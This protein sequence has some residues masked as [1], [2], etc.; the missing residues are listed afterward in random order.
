MS[1]TF[2]IA[3][4]LSFA[5]GKFLLKKYLNDD[6]VN[7]VADVL[8][9]IAK[10][11]IKEILDQKKAARA[12]EELA[13][14]IVAQIQELLEEERRQQPD[15]NV[16]GIAEQLLATL[17]TDLSAEFF[18]KGDLVPQRVAGNYAALRPLPRGALDP[19]SGEAYGRMLDHAARC[20]VGLA[21]QL[22]DF[23]VQTIATSLQ[24]LRS[25]EETADKTFAQ[26]RQMV[27][28][29]ERLAAPGD[30]QKFEIE[31]RDAVAKNFDF[32]DLFGITIPRELRRFQ[33][34]DAFVSLNLQRSLTPT[35][36]PARSK[37]RQPES[38]ETDEE[39]SD[40]ELL[41]CE[42]VLDRLRPG[43]GR[44]LIRGAA[45]SGKTTLMRWIAIQ[46]A[47]M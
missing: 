11:K 24:R 19:R 29:V 38:T 26:M 32:I 33:L 4:S 14:K 40:S 17:Q 20:L 44:L 31:Y 2:T 23:Q 25:L 15:L 21:N 46:A 18:V 7:T 10:P 16:E 8:T 39:K 41:S 6:G 22:P 1:L 35:K 37:K 34:T 45:G 28:A 36:N 47:S 43:E 5:F 3:N 30:A 12:V 27:T 13:D 9:D 42:A